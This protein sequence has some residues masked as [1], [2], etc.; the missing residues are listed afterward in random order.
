MHLEREGR[1]ADPALR[2]AEPKLRCRVLVV[3]ASWRAPAAAV[4]FVAT[5][6]GCV[7]PE[8]RPPTAADP[9]FSTCGFGTSAHLCSQMVTQYRSETRYRTVTKRVDVTDGACSQALFLAPMNKGVY[10]VDFTYRDHQVCAVTCVEQV[11][12][13]EGDGTFQNRPC[14]LPTAL[15]QQAL[16]ADRD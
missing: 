4:A 16:A 10:L 6:P 11:A 15:Q 3:I 7:P 2:R 5:V 14:P 9:Q 8:Y 1:R 13:D 12:T